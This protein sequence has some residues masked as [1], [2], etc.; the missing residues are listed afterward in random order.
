MADPTTGICPDFAA[1]FYENIR[2][3][4]HIATG[5]TDAGI[6]DRLIQSWTEGHNRR[7]GEW[8]RQREEEEQATAEAARARAAQE[9]E[10]RRQQETEAA[11]ELLE[12]EKKK[13]KTNDFSDKHSVGNFIVLRPL[14]AFKA[15]RAVL[16]DHQLSFSTF[17]RANSFL[18]HISK[19]KWPQEHVDSLSLFFWH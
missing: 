6:I 1:E 3:D 17:L 16:A 9:Q 18:S 4:I 7:I 2:G 14:S 19:A 11:K 13:P 8:N 12:A 5:Q 15:S 10:A